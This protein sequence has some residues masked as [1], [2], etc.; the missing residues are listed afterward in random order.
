MRLF[1]TLTFVVFLAVVGW[2]SANEGTDPPKVAGTSEPELHESLKKFEWLLGEWEA[3]VVKDEVHDPKEDKPV[4]TLTRPKHRFASD[5]V[6][7]ATDDGK[8]IRVSYEIRRGG[9]PTPF[10]TVNKL[11]EEVRW[12]G[13]NDVYSGSF[14]CDVVFVSQ[15]YRS[16]GTRIYS[17][18]TTGANGPK[19]EVSV[20]W[21]CEVLASG[22]EFPYQATCDFDCTRKDGD[23]IAIC[24]SNICKWDTS[25]D[26]RK[27]VEPKYAMEILLTRKPK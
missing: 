2:T 4:G 20:E 3:K 13:E 22:H 19:G 27:L 12:S 11:L 23:S 5:V 17:L 16:K 7:G 21:V 6:I 10:G 1:P 24:L 14:S 18:K 9:G 25:K 15:T 8:T 26:L